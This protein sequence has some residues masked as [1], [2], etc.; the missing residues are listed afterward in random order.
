MLLTSDSFDQ[1]NDL[2]GCDDLGMFFFR[3]AMPGRKLE[4]K[5]ENT[6]HIIDI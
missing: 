3:R 4:N 2:S 1:L 5:P 6:H